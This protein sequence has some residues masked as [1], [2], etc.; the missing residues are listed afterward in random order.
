MCVPSTHRRERLK[1]AIN[2]ANEMELLGKN[3]FGTGLILM[4]TSVWAQEHCL[5]QKPLL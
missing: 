5:R 1:I 2:Q 3:I 4:W